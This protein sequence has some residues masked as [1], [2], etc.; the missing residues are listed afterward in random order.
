VPIE[1]HCAIGV[2]ELNGV[3]TVYTSTQVP[4]YLPSRAGARAADAGRPHPRH[5]AVVGGGFG[6]KSEPF[7]LDSASRW[8]ALKTGR[9][10]KLLY[11]REEVFYAHRGPAPDAHDLQGGG[12]EGRCAHRP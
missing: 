6:G 7:D 12:L 11:T 10:V 9:P 4:H 1:P 3:I 8:L 2:P 5:P